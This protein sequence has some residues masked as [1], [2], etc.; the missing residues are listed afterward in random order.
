MSGILG[1]GV[2]VPPGQAPPYGAKSY[3]MPMTINHGLGLGLYEPCLP[4]RI[5]PVYGRDAGTIVLPSFY[6]KP[7]LWQ[8]WTTYDLSQLQPGHEVLVQL[9]SWENDAGGFD[10]SFSWVRLADN[11]V[12]WSGTYHVPPASAYGYPY[13][14]WYFVCSWIGYFTDVEI[15]KN[16]GYRSHIQVGDNGWGDPFTVTGITAIASQVKDLEV[17]YAK[18]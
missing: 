15:S 14:S 18:A 6:C 4:N 16:G 12:V 3:A 7:V 13:W 5:I 2:G 17:A 9:G 1:F 8:P 10:V 11:V